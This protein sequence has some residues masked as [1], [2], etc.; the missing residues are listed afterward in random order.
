MAYLIKKELTANLKYVVMGLGFFVLYAFIFNGNRAGLFMLCFVI[1]F[2][3]MSATNLV[4]DERY[5]IHLL[6]STLPIRRKD[7]VLSKYLMVAVLFA[8]SVVLYTLLAFGCR[9]FGYDRI[10]VLDFESAL[11]GLFA[12][13]VFNAV[14]LPLCYKFGA[15]ATRYVSFGIFFAFFFLSSFLGKTDLSEIFGFFNRLSGVQFGFILL[16]GAVVLNMVS[17]MFTYPIYEKKDL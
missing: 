6:L 2:Y 1:F 8:V 13:S 5:K 7:V 17:Y 15:E 16:G 11:T 10:P 14:M 3:S 4:L 9:A 12:V